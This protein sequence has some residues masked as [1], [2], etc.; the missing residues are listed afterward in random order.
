MEQ[1]KWN[2]APAFLRAHPRVALP[3]SANNVSVRSV[4]GRL[5]VGRAV[6]VAAGRACASICADGPRRARGGGRGEHEGGGGGAARTTL[7][8]AEKAK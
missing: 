7:A 2:G 6:A 3:P 4:R 5:A 8:G 1:E